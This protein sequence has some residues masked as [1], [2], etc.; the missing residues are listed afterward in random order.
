LGSGYYDA[1]ETYFSGALSYT[2]AK[3]F[4]FNG[5]ASLNSQSGQAEQLNPLMV[6]G[7]LNSKVVTPFTDL[8]VNIAP[9]WAWHGNWIHH[10]YTEAGGPGPAPRNFHGDVITLGVQYAF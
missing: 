1:P 4:R 3:Y 8:L 10:S 7:A 6:P 5:G 2:P 9:Q